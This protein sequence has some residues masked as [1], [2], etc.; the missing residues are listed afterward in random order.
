MG[1]KSKSSSN[2]SSTSTTSND[3][4]SATSSGVVT[5]GVFQG[6]TLN[7]TDAFGPEVQQAFSDVV[8][9][10]G[11]AGTLVG[12]TF[13]GL[14]QLAQKSIDLNNAATDRALT[15]VTQDKVASTNP[16]L[17][18]INSF[19]PVIIIALV[20]FMAIKGLK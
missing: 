7:Y 9:L 10:A 18:V 11:E 8:N 6:E 4:T 5:G 13:N 3:Q 19:I 1:G 2:T 16:Q 14:M 12:D 15:T 20:G 17:S